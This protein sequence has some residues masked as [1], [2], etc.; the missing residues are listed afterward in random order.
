MATYTLP[1]ATT[2]VLGGVKV[3]GT[4]ITING[5]GVISSASSG[6]YISPTL[7]G[8]TTIQALSEVVTGIV[9]ATGTVV[10]DYATAGSI[11]YHTDVASNF[12]ANFTNMP[13]TNG[14][15]YLIT[16]ILIQGNSPYIPN[17]VSVDGVS[18]NIYWGDNVQPAGT[19]LKREFFAFTLLRINNA[20]V[21]TAGV[22]S[23]G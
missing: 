21:I 15:S 20:W 1:T 18:Q 9:G 12:T 17:L 6:S 23:F 8:T 16:L 7:T 10:H 2:S 3:D 22:T 5:S 19:A 14:R 11:F 13:T 4:T